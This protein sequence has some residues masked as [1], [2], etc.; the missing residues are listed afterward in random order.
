MKI[1]LDAEEIIKKMKSSYKFEV[2][3]RYINSFNVTVPVLIF[4]NIKFELA[5]NYFRFK[6]ESISTEYR[7]E[8]IEKIMSVLK[9]IDEYLEKNGK[10]FIAINDGFDEESNKNVFRF[11]GVIHKG[12][13][14]TVGSNVIE[15]IKYD[16]GHKYYL[17]QEKDW[18]RYKIDNHSEY[19][20]FVGNIKN[21]IKL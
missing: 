21:A 5:Y 16:F 6:A 10:A 20:E 14:L 2:E 8:H 13:C 19:L 7:K 9:K 4:K 3:Y 17:T 18:K 1:Y 11:D 15:N 12:V